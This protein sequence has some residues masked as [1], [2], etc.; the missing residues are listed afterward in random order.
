LVDPDNRRPVDFDVR[1]EYLSRIDRG[2]LPAV[3]ETGAA[4]LLVTSRALRLR[5]DHPDWFSRYLPVPAY[6]AAADHVVA[7]DRGD[8]VTVATRLPLG[9]EAA[10]GWADTTLEIAGRSWIDTLTGERHRGGS[11]RLADL[12]RQYPVA[13]LVADEFDDNRAMGD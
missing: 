4:K 8:A 2:W 3:D 12:L 9:L 13:L 10:G 7:F 6:G 1:R 11:V 5:R